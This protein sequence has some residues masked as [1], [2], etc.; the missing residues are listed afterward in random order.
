MENMS[1][2]IIKNKMLLDPCLMCPSLW[3]CVLQ[4]WPHLLFT[5]NDLTVYVVLYVRYCL[6]KL[7]LPCKWLKQSWVCILWCEWLYTMAECLSNL[8][9]EERWELSYIR[10]K[11]L[12]RFPSL[13][14]KYLKTIS[15]FHSSKSLLKKQQQLTPNCYNKPLRVKTQ[16][17]IQNTVVCFKQTP[18]TV[19]HCGVRNN[20]Q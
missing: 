6:V 14:L 20:F 9:A 5:K 18:P 7:S 2:C 16:A 11:T 1:Q 17:S 8:Q 3:P 4:L 19:Y 13:P 15:T 10:N 12:G